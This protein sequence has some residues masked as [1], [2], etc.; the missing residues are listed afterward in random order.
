MKSRTSSCKAAAFKKDLTRFWPVWVGYILCLII[1]QVI[2]TNDDLTYWYAA[3]LGDCIAVMALVN[4]VYGLV[5]AQM[6]FGDLFSTRMCNG[7][8]SLPLKRQEWFGVHVLSGFL[9]SLVP[10]AL[11]AGFS[12]IVISL[13][14]TMV[15]GWQIPLYWFAAANLQYVF[16]FGLAVFC[17]MCT[18]SRFAATVVY[19]ILN[20]F[21][22]LIYVLVYQLYTPLLYGV[23][24]QS[25]FFELL[26][27]VVK[28][29]ALRY[30]I[31]DRIDT[32]RT[33]V[34]AFGVEQREFVGTFTVQ[35]QGWVYVL[36]LAAIGIALLIAARQMYK[37]RNLECAG[38][39]L[40]VR[41]LEPV[42]QVVFTVLCAAGFHGGIGIF[43]GT[44]SDL[45]VSVIAIGLLVGWFAG[46]M[47]LER[48]TRVFRMKN[49]IGFFLIAA[50]MAGSLFITHLD[51]LGIDDWIP[52]AGELKGAY[53]RMNYRSEFNS[54]D[55]QVMED[56]IRLQ[57]LALQQRVEV[58]PDYDGNYYHPQGKNPKAVQVTFGFTRSSGWLS[59]RQYHVLADG[60]SGEILRKYFSR[61][62][63]V[64]DRDEVNNPEDLRHKLKGAE[65]ISLNGRSVPEK[66]MTAEFRQALADAIAADCA[67]GRMVQ[68]GAFHPEPILDFDNDNYD[69]YSM[70]LDINGSDFW[71]YVDIYADCEN[72]LAVLQPTGILETIR[73][74]Y[75]NSPG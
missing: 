49:F 21:A 4:A 61:L 65:H 48:T 74:D 7:I 46:R 41:W 3:N 11:M 70:N 22:T 27:P 24:T 38:D 14:S 54:D 35:P 29:V 59:Q 10:A 44:G 8:H 60:E 69:L 17:I 67:A 58:H 57:E 73:Q 1:I 18:G 37:K 2:I 5:T 32:G 75:A 52:E 51:P 62:D 28:L 39:F 20:F 16:F 25:T 23:V 43:F 13:Y 19:G 47:F 26:S 33:Y 63:T 40:A 42:F 55:P 30:L 64:I 9:F 34:D 50:A 31:A 12:G 66:F 72:I 53:F 71:F 56:I 68:S 15:S 36:I 45:S 6:L